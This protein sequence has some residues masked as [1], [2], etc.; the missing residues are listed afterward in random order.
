M[1]K[2]TIS[3]QWIEGKDY[4]LLPREEEH[5]HVNI[6]KGD[7]SSCIISYNKVSIDEK[8][9]MLK[10]DYTLEYTPVDGVTADDPQLQKTASHILHSILM[11]IVDK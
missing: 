3:E 5:W 1:V 2:T 9:L 6:L 10:F 8:N 7:Y 4:E 11:G